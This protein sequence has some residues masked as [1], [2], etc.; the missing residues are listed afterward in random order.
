MN[1]ESEKNHASS[2]KNNQ[3]VTTCGTEETIATHQFLCAEN[4]TALVGMHIT[5]LNMMNLK[6]ITT[7]I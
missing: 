4:I 6:N 5:R 3:N 7:L 2:V 1:K